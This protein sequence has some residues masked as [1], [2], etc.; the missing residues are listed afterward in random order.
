[1][2]CSCLHSMIKEAARLDIT[3]IKGENLKKILNILRVSSGETKRDLAVKSGL[4]FSTVSNL[5]NELK[6]QQVLLEEKCNDYSVGRNP[7]KLIFQLQRYCSFCI[8]FQQEGTM[9]L[10]VLDFGNHVRYQAHFNIVAAQDISEPL[11]IIQETY[12]SLCAAPDFQDV[13]FVGS[14]V[15]IP[16]IFDR[17]TGMVIN[18]M[19]PL[20]NGLPL[21]ELIQRKLSLPCYVDNE[22]NLCA[23]SVLQSHTDAQ[24]IVYI[25]SSAGLGVGAICNGRL[26][27]GCGGY[28]AEIACIP[29]GNPDL[30]C[31]NCGGKG[32]IENDLGQRGMDTLDFP[33]LS[34]EERE[35]LFR[36]RGGKLGELIALLINLFDPSA[37]Y[38]GGPAMAHYEDLAPYFQKVLQLRSR[39]NMQRG[40]QIFHDPDSLQNIEVGINQTVYENWD[41]I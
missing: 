23:L 11:Q 7:S 10:A 33:S 16:G 38:V 29:L 24:D 6:E 4:S 25:H 30:T 2:E 32:C 21:A 13:T 40:V 5:C 12:Q 41:P 19:N 20:L 27:R 36:D 35:S 1:M 22:S 14:G 26:L 9:N 17:Q 28:A 15:S 37:V 39:V 18:S 31:P 3:D 8:D 34:P